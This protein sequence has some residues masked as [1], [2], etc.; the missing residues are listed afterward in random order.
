MSLQ[1]ERCHACGHDHGKHDHS[2]DRYNKL[3]ETLRL[4]LDGEL[5]LQVM[6]ALETQTEAA[7]Q[8]MLQIMESNPLA[9]V[10]VLS[11]DTK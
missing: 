10:Q 2:H 9:F 4:D 6:N 8:Q 1:P 5:A 7:F 3:V 11:I